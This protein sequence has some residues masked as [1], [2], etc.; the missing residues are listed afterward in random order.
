MRKNFQIHLYLET[1]LVEKIKK[2]ATERKISVTS[3][4]RQKLK[5]DTQLDRI[6]QTIG[7]IYKLH[8]VQDSN[9]QYQKP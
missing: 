1:E 5:E 9:R 4:C 8:C 6:E 2:Q 7:K 3:L